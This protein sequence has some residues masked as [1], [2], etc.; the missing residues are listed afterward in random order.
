[1]P[2]LVNV[3]Q[4]MQ[5][6]V[7]L[8]VDWYFDPHILELETQLLFDQGV[9]YVGHEAMLQSV[10]DYQVL[11]WMGDAKVFLRNKIPI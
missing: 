3:S 9:G 8:P 1:M 2:N 5:R 6:P 11:E 4:R 7:Q 10:G